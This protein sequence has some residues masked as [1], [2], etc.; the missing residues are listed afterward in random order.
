MSEASLFI[1][2]SNNTSTNPSQMTIQFPNQQIFKNKEIAL[3][4]LIIYYS[5]RN[6]TAA[7]TNNDVSYN[8]N[9]VNHPIIFPDGFYTTSTTEN[10]INA[11]IQ[12]QMLQNGHYLK[13]LNGNIIYYLS[14]SLNVVYYAF[15]LTC[16]PIP[17]SLPTGYTNPANV[18]LSGFT[19]QL[20]VS[21][22]NFKTIIGFNA[23]SYPA[24][25]TNTVVYQINSAV[26]P[27]TSPINCVIL[28][29]NL[30][31]A[32]GLNLFPDA[33]HVFTP[34]VGYGSQIIERPSRLVF[35]PI[36]DG[37]YSQMTL[38]FSDGLGRQLG[39]LDPTTTIVQLVIR[40]K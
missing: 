15:T 9:G 3:S 30:V 29:S 4:N 31:A 33:L 18:T 11:Y 16:T 8:W 22:S 13:D 34:T 35:F 6:I 36:A 2:T 1:N 24:S 25:A 23:G 21:N 7:F 40:N 38:T 27:E 37:S 5:W 14:L 32:N 39:I 26:T 10:D 19:P 12:L 28:R 20:V 17:T